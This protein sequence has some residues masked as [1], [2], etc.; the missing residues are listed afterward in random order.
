MRQIL[1]YIF[2]LTTGYCLAQADSIPVYT[3]QEDSLPYRVIRLGMNSGQADYSPVMV[4]NT[5]YF[6]SSRP[7]DFGVHYS[8]ANSAE[9]MTDLFRADK[10]DSVKFKNV[11]TLSKINTPFNEGPFTMS[12]DGRYIYYTGNE[13]QVPVKGKANTQLKIFYSAYDGKSWSVPLKPAFCKDGYA[14]AHP[15]L[16]ADKNMLVFC[17]DLPGGYGGMDLYASY[18]KNDAWSQP[19]NLGPKING[20]AHELF[21]YISDQGVLY[22]S[23]ERV[24][25]FGGLDIYS[26]DLNDTTDKTLMHLPAPLNSASDDFGIWTDSLNASGYFSSNRSG[27][28]D[29]YYFGSIQ[30]DFSKASA[31]AMKTKFCY[32]FFEETA[33]ETQDS[34]SF[35]YEW[36]LGDGTRSRELRTK[37][38]YEKPGTYTVSLNAVEKTTGEIFANQL[39]YELM[40]E[41]PPG[42]YITCAD[43]VAFKRE[44]FFNTEQCEVKGC[45][46]KQVYWDFGDGRYSSGRYVKHCYTKPGRYWVRLGVTARNTET[47]KDELFKTT[48]LITII[49]N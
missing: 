26:M 22:F 44:L 5:L 18:R 40:I 49:E 17:S 4:N 48:R 29:I 16:S 3:T 27:N 46:L 30:P 37:H 23:S 8:S 35:S 9:P 1:L 21:P 15:A 12:K 36:D 39:T 11:S 13:K 14:Y 34:V 2:L 32:T 38:C 33:L 47:K 20:R 41:P 6:V 42:L 25:G 19:V 45:E 24:K 43:S 10:K 31:P 28:D 7:S